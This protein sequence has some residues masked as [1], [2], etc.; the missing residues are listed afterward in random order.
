[1][2]LNLYVADIPELMVSREFS[3]KQLI[4]NECVREDV[5]L[6][7]GA[8]A[9]GV[10]REMHTPDL[11]IS[12]GDIELARRTRLHFD[13]DYESV[14]MH[15]ALNGDTIATSQSFKKHVNFKANQHNIIYANRFRG[16]MEWEGSDFRIFEVNMAPSFFKRFLPE[17]S[18]DIFDA[19]RKQ[20]ENGASSLITEQH[21]LIDM[22]MYEIIG[23]IIR[24]ERK[25]LFKKIFLET[26]VLELLLLQ[27][28]QLYGQKYANSSI[29]SSD[30]KKMY[31]V[32]DFMLSNLEASSSLVE[33]AHEVGTNEFT[34]K[35]GF[36]EIFG[37][38][39]YGYWT[40]VKMEEAR[41]MLQKNDRS[42][43]EIATAIGYKNP[44]HFT[45]A[46]KRKYN[47]LPSQ[48]RRGVM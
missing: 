45:S 21:Q 32:R 33:L 7:N 17:D 8:A 37:T 9:S 11:H 43:A 38:T 28:E 30:V 13:S 29:K 26:K 3:H 1:M 5:I 34:L 19:F 18:C 10:Y 42:I 39:V 36:K 44:Q 24:C 4:H 22:Q 25:G 20:I 35:K 40:D 41:K 14:E 48:L 6:L 2:G 31:A 27:L 16:K 46:F 47:I 15:F 12:Y 23:Q